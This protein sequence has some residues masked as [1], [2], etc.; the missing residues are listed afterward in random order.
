MPE[1][2]IL[3]FT[4]FWFMMG[5]N[6]LFKV[7]AKTNSSFGAQKTPKTLR[8]VGGREGGRERER[9][10]ERERKNKSVLD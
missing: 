10:R 5:V 6:T 2:Y 3:F 1:S 4:E 8:E 7:K 9:E